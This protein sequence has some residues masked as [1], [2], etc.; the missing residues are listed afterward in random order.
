MSNTGKVIQKNYPEDKGKRKKD[1]LV[2]GIYCSGYL[3]SVGVVE[4]LIQR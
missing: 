4:M 1:L 3:N 2:R